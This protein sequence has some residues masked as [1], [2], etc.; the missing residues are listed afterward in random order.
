MRIYYMKRFNAGSQ[1]EQERSNAMEATATDIYIG[2]K[3]ND[4]EIAADILLLKIL[5]ENPEKGMNRIFERY[6]GYVYTIV[7]S[8]LKN[9]PEEDIEECV[10]DVFADLYL[11][12]DRIDSGKGGIKPYLITLA[13]GKAISRYRQLSAQ[14]PG[15]S[16]DDENLGL[17][18]R[19]PAENDPAAAAERAQER[20]ALITA[21]KSL[22]EPDSSILIRKYYLKESISQIAQGLGISE[23]TVVKRTKRS[24]KKL[25]EEL[26]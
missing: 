12:R 17:E 15:L 6:V 19:L 8:R 10:S 22:G 4:T 13:T 16:I 9:Y 18:S 3:D 2:K 21:V 1:G 7:R 23:S 14:K 26:S 5:H 25:K 11:R 20:R 24:L